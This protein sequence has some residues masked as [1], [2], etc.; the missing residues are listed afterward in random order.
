MIFF[1]LTND[2]KVMKDA[3]CDNM[4]KCVF[5][6]YVFSTNVQTDFVCMKFI[7]VSWHE[8]VYGYIGNSS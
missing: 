6:Q 8:N 5:R 1:F 2:Q 7:M 3:V 4:Y